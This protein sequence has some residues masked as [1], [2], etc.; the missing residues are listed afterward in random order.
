VPEEQD[1]KEDGYRDH[2]ACRGAENRAQPGAAA[3]PAVL[4]E[5][6]R[7]HLAGHKVPRKVVALDHLTRNDT[8][9][10]MKRELDGQGQL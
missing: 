7:G 5:P 8:G 10:V 6:V 3:T 2:A 4:K 9:K 1:L